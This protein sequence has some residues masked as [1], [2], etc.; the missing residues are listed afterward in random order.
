M[1]TTSITLSVVE[2]YEALT[3]AN[4]PSSTVPRID[5]GSMAQVVSS[6]QVTRPTVRLL[7]NGREVKPVDFERNSVVTTR[8]AFEVWARSLGDVDTIVN[9]IRLNGGTIGSGSGFDYGTLSTLTSPK[10]THQIVPASEPRTL[11]PSLDADGQRVHGALLEY[12]VEV[13]ER[14]G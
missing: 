8:F 1:A 5:F 13:L 12:A 6:T 3:A 9:A 14:A 10:S 2:K 11:A 7:D 4:F